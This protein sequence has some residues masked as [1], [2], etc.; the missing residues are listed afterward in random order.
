MQKTKMFV[1]SV[2]GFLPIMILWSVGG[3]FGDI[4]NM[5]DEIYL[6]EKEDIVLSAVIPF[7]VVHI[8]PVLLFV[9]AI[10]GK[11]YNMKALYIS[12]AV[13]VALPVFAFI[14]SQFF[15]DDGNILSWIYS[16]TIGLIL[17]PFGRAAVAVFDGIASYQFIYKDNYVFEREPVAALYVVF[18][19]AS[20]IIYSIVRTRKS[21]K[22]ENTIQ[23][24][25]AE[26]N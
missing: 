24:V 3:Y 8:I 17:Y 14:T 15:M 22:T 23:T 18:I 11:R 6:I 4:E 21:K 25:D 5:V 13:A 2:I 12:A 20:A 10:I 26:E 7:I 16:F 9:A 1:Q 19:I